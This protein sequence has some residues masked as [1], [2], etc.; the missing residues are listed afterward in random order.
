[1]LPTDDTGKEGAAKKRTAG[2]KAKRREAREH[3][4]GK[5]ISLGS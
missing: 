5:P 1:M 2:A 3:M 4:W